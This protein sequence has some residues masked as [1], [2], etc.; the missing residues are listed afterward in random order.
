M[1]LTFFNSILHGFTMKV[2]LFNIFVL[3]ESADSCLATA[4]LKLRNPGNCLL[5]LN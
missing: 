1:K 2:V 3:G 5:K 4:A